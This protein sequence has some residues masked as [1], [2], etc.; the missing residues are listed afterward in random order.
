MSMPNAPA[1]IRSYCPGRA[2]QG[3][4]VMISPRCNSSTEAADSRRSTSRWRRRF[5]P[6]RTYSNALRRCIPIM[7]DC[8]AGWRRIA[9][10]RRSS[11]WYARP[12]PPRSERWSSATDPSRSERRAGRPRETEDMPLNVKELIIV[13]AL[14]TLVFAVGRSTALQFMD[15]GDFKRRRNVWLI[16]SAAA[17]LSPNFWLFALVAAPALYIG[18]RKDGN[19]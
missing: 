10:R 5:T 2:M 13:L 14:S 8:F 17:F 9:N 19:P 1:S 6:H 15:E 7:D 3:L 4:P 12:L 18:G 11:I 16:L